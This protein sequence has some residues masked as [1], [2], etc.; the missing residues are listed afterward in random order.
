MKT[1]KPIRPMF[2]TTI[3]P[4]EYGIK[5]QMED[6]VKSAN[7]HKKCF[8]EMDV[9]KIWGLY[10][11]WDRLTNGITEREDKPRD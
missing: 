3:D 5:T 9:G 4:S 11:A 1:Q 6:M 7:K 10:Q 8:I 2:S